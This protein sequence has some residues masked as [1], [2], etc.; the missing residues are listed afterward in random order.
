MKVKRQ[1]GKGEK[2]EGDRGEWRIRREKKEDE[3]RENDKSKK[4]YK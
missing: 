4:W 2:T 3:R 1:K